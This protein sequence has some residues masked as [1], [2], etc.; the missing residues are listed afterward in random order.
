MVGL[1]RM[2]N[3]KYG[4]CALCNRNASTTC[5][6]TGR[7]LCTSCVTILVKGKQMEIRMKRV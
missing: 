1:W 4:M 2:E 6:R 3:K 5:D 7:H